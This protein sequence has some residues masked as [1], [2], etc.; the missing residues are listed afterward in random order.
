MLIMRQACRRA[1]TAVVRRQTTAPRVFSSSGARQRATGPPTA[2]SSSKAE[3]ATQADMYQHPALYDE[4]FS[5]RDFSEE[6]AFVQAAYK[7]H[8]TGS[9]LD[10]LLELGWVRLW[11]AM[12]GWAGGTAAPDI[13]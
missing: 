13:S 1:A 6:A 10:T 4:V 7:R 3:A 5:Y 9:R 11:G 2:G 12:M 8:C